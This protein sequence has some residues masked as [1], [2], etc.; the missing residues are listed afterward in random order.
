MIT[1][2]L[3]RYL[4][5]LHFV[6]IIASCGCFV[7]KQNLHKCDILQNSNAEVQQDE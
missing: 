2:P 1:Y 6:T 7:T 3:F 4:V 5:E